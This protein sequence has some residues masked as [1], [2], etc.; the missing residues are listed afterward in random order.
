MT[1]R[2]APNP[3]DSPLPLAAAPMAGGPTTSRLAAAVTEA[4]AF[5]FLAG[6]Y[7]PPRRWPPRLPTSGVGARRS[8]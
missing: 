6:G 3:L 5:P 7:K 8:G 1:A 4:A 2:T